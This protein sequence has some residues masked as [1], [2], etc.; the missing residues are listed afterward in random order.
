MLAVYKERLWPQDVVIDARSDYGWSNEDRYQV[1]NAK[2]FPRYIL[3]YGSGMSA[4]DDPCSPWEVGFR[5][6][7]GEGRGVR[8]T[9]G[10][11]W[12]SFSS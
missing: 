9:R 4:S 5:V 8:S 2:A 11:A 12:L 1:S 7:E 3:V 6:G 10:F